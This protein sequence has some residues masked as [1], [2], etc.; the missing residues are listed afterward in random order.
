MNFR[1]DLA[2]ELREDAGKARLDGVECKNFKRGN[3]EIT[4]ISVTNS[5]GEKSLGKPKGEY[6]TVQTKSFAHSSHISDELVDTVS[7][8]LGRLIPKEG[9]VLAAGLGNT[10]I[11]PDALGPEFIKGIFVTRHLKRELCDSLG[12]GTLRPVAAVAPGV[13]GQ[14]GVETGE[15]LL[16]AVNVIKP[17][18]VIVVDALAAR[19]LERLGCTVQISDS[20]IIPGSGVGNSRTEIS[21]KTLGVPVIS[22]G[23]PTVVDAK[24]LARDVSG[25]AAESENNGKNDMMVTPKEIDILIERCSS[26]ISLAVNRALQPSLSIETLT[27]LTR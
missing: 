6:I 22:I 21:R 18:A 27:A 4:R 3:A 14:T 10:N 15:L 17:C 5:Q 24:T 13:L 25:Y 7:Q 1:T 16:G 2:V 8:E 26:L 19:R 11:T 9:T 12:L 23:V 20:G